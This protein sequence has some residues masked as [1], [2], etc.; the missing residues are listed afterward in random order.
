MYSFNSIDGGVINNEPYGIGLKVLFEK[1]DNLNEN[2]N[3]AVIMIDPFPNKDHDTENKSGRSI[4]DVA[5]G[6]FKALR[7]QVMFNQDGILEALD[8]NNR[9][10]F[11]I[12]PVRKTEINGKRIR[13]K[14]DLASAPISGFAGFLNKNFRKHDFQLG[15]QNC[16]NFLRYY[17]AVKEEN[18]ESRL[19]VNVHSISKERFEFAKPARDPNGEKYFPI[20]PDM[21]MLK[22]F[23]EVVDATN[24]G[25]DAKIK[26][27]NYPELSF[28]AF[29]SKYKR[30]IKRRIGAVAN[31]LVN[32][33]LFNILNF[34]YLRG[35]LYKTVRK[36]IFDEL[37]DNDLLN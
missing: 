6:M 26:L 32:N 23:E 5:K 37:K 3:F 30:S 31:K 35:K 17:F 22:N 14:N 12:E 4:V 34:V 8:T 20:I 15:R 1:N 29:E 11:L 21:R 36:S 18:I 24:Y 16:Q 2:N 13:A 28:V 27:L 7:N 19:G 25:E 9:T 33:K 10:K